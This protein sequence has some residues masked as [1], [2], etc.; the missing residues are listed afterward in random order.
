M[1]I[2]PKARVRLLPEN[3]TQPAIKPT[4][5]IL[6]TAIDGANTT[7]LYDWFNGSTNLES[8]FYVGKD[9]TV[10]QYMDTEVR[11]DANNKANGRAVSIETWDGR[12]PDKPANP[13]TPA[14]VVALVELV[15]WLCSTHSIP[16]VIAPAWDK[17]GIGWHN[18]YPEW[19]PGATGCPGPVRAEQVVTEILPALTPPP[20]P[21]PTP[22]GDDEMVFITSPGTT[23]WFLYDGWRKRPL[24]VG[25]NQLLV[26]LGIV[27]P[28]AAGAP[29]VKVLT[30]AQVNAIPNG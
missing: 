1:A 21:T 30:D 29:F 28:N 25:E 19:S 12:A 4:Q 15:G 8:H 2:Y 11:A 17:P 5:V 23:V 20:P 24:G 26:D 27:K 13:W 10:E 22:A 7:S 18:L 16:R 3:A 14:Q 9:G 6:H